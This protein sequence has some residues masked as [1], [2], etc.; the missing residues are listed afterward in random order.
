MRKLSPNSITQS[1]IAEYLNGYSDFSF[2]IKVLKKFTNLGY[3]CEHGGTYEDPVTG[4]SREFD[5]RA[6]IQKEF[7]RVHYYRNHYL[8]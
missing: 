3:E 7:V 6:L 2:E 4:K 8:W 1:D 5:I